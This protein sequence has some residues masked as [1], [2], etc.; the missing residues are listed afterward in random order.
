MQVTAGRLDRP[1]LGQRFQCGTERRRSGRRIEVVVRPEQRDARG[2]AR[3]HLFERLEVALAK[4]GGEDF[5]V[6]ERVAGLEQHVPVRAAERV[7]KVRVGPGRDAAGQE[8]PMHAVQRQ[9]AR[10]LGAQQFDD[11]GFEVHFASRP[12][13]GRATLR[14]GPGQVHGGTGRLHEERG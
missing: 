13:K 5:T 6:A 4:R 12:L 7:P 11:A 2:M 3:V 8:R 14:A 10:R 9:R 1:Q